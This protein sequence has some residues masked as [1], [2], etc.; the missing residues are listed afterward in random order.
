M[1]RLLAFTVLLI[2]IVLCVLVST[3]CQST[4]A[5]DEFETGNSSRDIHEQVNLWGDCSDLPCWKGIVLGE[6][7]YSEAKAILEIHY[8]L[9]TF[10]YNSNTI[11]WNIQNS[12]EAGNVTFQ[13]NL[14]ST[15]AVGL[16]DGQLVAEELIE[17]VGE[18]DDVLLLHFNHPERKCGIALLLFSNVGILASVLPTDDGFVGVS[19]DQSIYRLQFSLHANDWKGLP[20]TTFLEWIGYEN[21]C[22]LYSDQ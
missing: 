15:I 5:V 18:P 17:Q 1:K 11:A 16:L 14:A 10:V 7:D 6:T 3:G 19:P 22:E 21:Y 9:E 13:D 12:E 4:A 2:L 20:H 8:D